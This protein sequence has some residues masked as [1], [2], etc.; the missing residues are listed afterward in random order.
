[1]KIS[2]FP[3][4]L[5][6]FPGLPLRLHIFE[7]RY[8]EMVGECREHN[9][10]FGVVCAQPEGFAIIGCFAEIV[11][12]LQEYSDGRL[13]ILCRGAERFEIESLDNSRSFLQ[14]EVDFFQDEDP[15]AT[16]ALRE[17]CV[18]LHFEAAELMDAGAPQ[19]YLDFDRPISFQL[20]SSAPCDLRLKQELLALRSDDERSER[21]LTFY[22]A[23]LPKLRRGVRATRVASSN[24]HLM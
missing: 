9:R 10:G 20:A 2:L 22:E 13:D 19:L 24:G 3:L 18:A 6:L 16:R 1:M 21:L 23:M 14:A 17:R 5:V 8:K 7:N 15:G 11:R 4:N 12:V